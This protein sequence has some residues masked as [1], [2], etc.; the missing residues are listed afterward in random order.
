MRRQSRRKRVKLCVAG[1][2]LLGGLAGSVY[3]VLWLSQPPTSG[4]LVIAGLEAPISISFDAYQR[5]YVQAE[6]LVDALCAQGWLH[7][8]HR[9]WQMEMFRRAGKG[10]LAELLGKSMLDADRELWRIGVPQLAGELEKNASPELSDNVA[11]YV[12]GVNAAITGRSVAPPEFLLLQSEVEPWTAADVYALGALMAYQSSNNLTNEL[13]RLALKEKLTDEE[14]AVFLTDNSDRDDYPFVLPPK[15][16]ER[17]EVHE[18]GPP[19]NAGEARRVGAIL[20]RLAAIEPGDSSLVPRLGFGSNGWVVAPG[21]SENGYA[22]FA[23]DS[24]DELGLPNLFYE[25]HLF[26]GDGR[27]IRGWSAAG[28]PGVING[29]NERIAWGFT[30]IGDTQ[31][32]FLET[33]SKDDP[34]KFKDGQEWYEARTETVSIPVKGR[35]T[36]ESLTVVHTR[37][38]VLI[39][40]DPPIALR[41]TTQDLNTMGLDSLLDLNRAGNWAEFNAALDRFAAPSLNA[42]YADV[43]GNIGFRTTGILPIR[44]RGQGLYPLAGDVPDNRWQGLVAPEHMPRR[45][46]PPAGYLAAANARVNSSGDGALVSADNAAPYRIQRLHDVLG[47]ERPFGL[48][49]MQRLQ[50]DWHDG[51]AEQLM[52]TLMADL[53]RDTLSPLAQQAAD[54]LDKWQANP[55]AAR[56]ST[57]ALIFQQWYLEIA[58]AVFA[59]RLGEPLY[60]R[61]LKRNYVLN[62]ALDGLI[63]QEDDPVWWQGAKGHKL[64]QSL[65]SAVEALEESLGSEISEWRLERRQRV[66]LNHELGKAEPM[67]APLFNLAP[68]GWGGGP[69]M[70]GRANYRYDRPFVVSHGA[71]LRVVAEMRPTPTV[72][73]VIAGGQSGHPLSAHYDDQFETWLSGDLNQISQS[74]PGDDSGD[75]LV[76][77]PP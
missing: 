74:P 20:D 3:A 45:F 21:K 61:L 62:H 70:L 8:S 42:T 19:A 77:T 34:L 36:P 2:A 65:E 69:A 43:D 16:H 18:P 54:E 17:A 27:Q 23:F 29:Y 72:K 67:L 13:L 63:L 14:F 44:G 9:L 30:N 6:S 57:G 40:E 26:F 35:D 11:A 24:H 76:L 59:E 75:V 39:S 50:L 1:L 71:T 68:R 55:I 4:T 66:A 49:D 37:N 12:R 41:W 73:S 53:R 51:Q 22:L 10:R 33:R 28:L 52:P 60:Q 64:A 15:S 38:G 32:L 25:V 31:D 5:P 46:N 58:R 48:K 7:A 56:D 47:R